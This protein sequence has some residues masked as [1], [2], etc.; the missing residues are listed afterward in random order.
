[1]LLEFKISNYKSFYD[2]TV[3]SMV[4]APRQTGL[5]YSI[6]SEK[7]GAKKYRGL[8]SAVIYGPNASGK[9]NLIGAMEAMRAIVLRGNIKDADTL[10]SPNQ[11]AY[12]LE[13]IPNCDSEDVPVCFSIQFLERNL[14][15]SYSFSA[16][17]GSFLEKDY[18]RRVV[19]EELLVNEKQV[20]LRD[21]NGMALNIP[22]EKMEQISNWVIRGIEWEEEG[23]EIFSDYRSADMSEEELDSY[24]L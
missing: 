21:E 22:L 13:L 17:L 1:M 7:I 19:R 5:D 9:T 6:Q 11:A 3:F 8:S 2:E 24:D 4:P 12:I 14:A 20:F 15:I 10:A 18:K 16:L 23:A